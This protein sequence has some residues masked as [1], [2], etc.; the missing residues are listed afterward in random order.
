MTSKTN[1]VSR[2][3]A[4]LRRAAMAGTALSFIALA[5]AFATPTT[6]QLPDSSGWTVSSPVSGRTVT[7]KGNGVGAN[8]ITVSD[9][10]DP[11]SEN[12]VITTP[13][14]VAAAGLQIGSGAS[15][16]INATNADSSNG[17]TLNTLI[18]D[19]SGQASDIE[20]KLTYNTT[21][22]A[23]VTNNG[24]LFIANQNGIIVGSGANITAPT[25]IYLEG[26]KATNFSAGSSASLAT[27]YASNQLTYASAPGNGV[28]TISKGAV[29]NAGGAGVTGS[30]GTVVVA[31]AGAI[32]ISQ[33][34]LE[35]S[36]QLFVFS[37]LNDAGA[38]FSTPINGAGVTL[39]GVPVV[40][41]TANAPTVY[42]YGTGAVNIT[43]AAAPSG[44][45][46]GSV[47]LYSGYS[48]TANAYATNGSVAGQDAIPLLGNTASGLTLTAAQIAAQPVTVNGTAANVALA[49][50][51]VAGNATTSGSVTITG[52]ANNDPTIAG[53]LENT[54]GGV[55]TL[56]SAKDNIVNATTFNNDAGAT[57][58]FTATG[59]TAAAL[60][61]NGTLNNSG[62]FDVQST[63]DTG[64]TS[65]T[66]LVNGALTNN[67]GATLQSVLSTYGKSN[68]A[69]TTAT[70]ANGGVT[71]P[72]P[73]PAP[74]GTPNPDS[75]LSLIVAP[76]AATVTAP[77]TT[78]N[79]I[80]N[81]T[82]NAVGTAGY[83]SLSIQASNI[84]L[85]GTVLANGLATSE[86]ITPA[87]SGAAATATVN[88]ALASLTLVA[89]NG[90]T[91]TSYATMYTKASSAHPGFVTG[92]G[93]SNGVIDYNTN[94]VVANPAAGAQGFELNAGAVR[95]LS[96]SSLVDAGTAGTPITDVIVTGSNNGLA[97]PFTGSTLNY[98]MSVFPNA[99]VNSGADQ[100]LIDTQVNYNGSS[101]VSTGG[102]GKN[103]S[104]NNV[105]YTYGNINNVGT[106]G[107]SQ[108][109]LTIV[110]NNINATNYSTWAPGLEVGTGSTLTL[111]F[112]GN[113]NNQ[114]GPGMAGGNWQYNYIPVMI[115]NTKL[116]QT[117]SAT[118][119][120]N[121]VG[122]AGWNNLTYNNGPTADAA[123]VLGV[124]LA[125]FSNDV[126][127]AILAP[128]GVAGTAA[129]YVNLMVN[130]NVT[131][132][133]GSNTAPL[134]AVD[135]T[136]VGALTA[137]TAAGVNNAYGAGSATSLG[138]DNHLVIQS[139]GNI[140]VDKVSTAAAAF[141]PGLVYLRTVSA[142]SGAGVMNISSTG[143][144]TLGATLQTATS[145]ML[146]STSSASGIM[147]ATNAL[148]MNA[149]L[150]AL[151]LGDSLTFSSSAV[152]QS[153]QSF[154]AGYVLQAAAASSSTAALSVL[155]YSQLASS[156]YLVN[157]AL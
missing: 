35:K 53:T 42:V 68:S 118:V 99:V 26:Y 106:L 111:Y 45:V 121:S 79:F 29:I 157:S 81:G 129:Q 24:S 84:A 6:S 113:I 109:A 20:G 94:V 103:P 89:T 148:Y 139:S 67:S 73:A 153:T 61:L 58:V 9:A 77:A 91:P 135:N 34:V 147:F 85:N 62:V 123:A 12:F 149:N 114:A 32:N 128:G 17:Y 130:G 76:A 116:G 11:G 3:G 10:T 56:S 66:L 143:S 64:N 110:A 15:L 137:T 7:I 105:V 95:F 101:G 13:G 54:A 102:G 16:T 144:V 90:V 92:S 122:T 51:M 55:L 75:G 30:V 142:S 93:L 65:D 22:T 69:T 146:A 41:G 96:G 33:P 74:G 49:D 100:M 8:N 19:N 86:T 112:A 44:D 40:A 134:A 83:P 87:T 1:Y 155:N 124:A 127:G 125:G 14:G 107:S 59:T 37:G 156:G 23:G 48:D 36:S 31:G 140:T 46:N 72:F 117:G 115:G 145:V 50:F 126:T 120:L 154:N 88:N 70:G 28:V 152:A 119:A 136:S 47:N 108:N 131:F 39:T 80:N 78:G 63:T 52:S 133:S 141:W 43:G 104:S 82:I 71:K 132:T 60:T 21:S 5:P 2:Q 4:L 98:A 138:Y 97:D 57:T 151:G 18:I 25:N 38:A 27:N 150:L